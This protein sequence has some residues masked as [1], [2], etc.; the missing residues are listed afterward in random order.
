MFSRLSSIVTLLLL[1][2]AAVAEEDSALTH[3]GLTF[4]STLKI[5]KASAAENQVTVEFDFIN[6]GRE[7]VFLDALETHCSCLGGE[8]LPKRLYPEG[9]K[10]GESGKIRA[11]FDLGQF[12]GEVEK[13][14]G[15]RLAGEE[16]GKITLRVRVHVP[17]LFEIEP[18]TLVWGLGEETEPQVFQIKV[19]HETPINILSHSMSSANFLYNL[20]VIEP[21]RRYEVTV[22][23]ESTERAGLGVLQFRTDCDIPKHRNRQAFVV[24]RKPIPK[25]E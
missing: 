17:V 8:I 14:I 19:T 22:T 12:R 25:A 6:S 11:V 24:V 10:P 20:K 21:G 9:V 3:G 1:S 16:K 7:K 18:M 4:P 2:I 15:V 5:V 13:T 23:P